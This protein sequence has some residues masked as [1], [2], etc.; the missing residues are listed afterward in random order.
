MTIREPRENKGCPASR[1]HVRSR[2]A[3]GGNTELAEENERSGGA[4][5]GGP[6]PVGFA[7]ALGAAAHDAAVAAQARLFL[8]EQTRL[9]HA[10]VTLVHLQS[11]DLR[12]EDSIRHWSLRVRHVSDV[13]KLGFELAVAFIVLALAIGVGAVIWQAVHA[14]G[15]VIRTFEVPQTF[16]AK[17][18]SGQVVA[19]KLLDRLTRM[20]GETDSSRAA[21]SFANDWTNDIK[22]EIPDTA[23]S[24]GEA[25]RFLDGWLGHEMHLSGELYE[26]PSGIALT[27][28]T[29]NE[30]G[31]TF[32][33]KPGELDS[34]I[35]RAAEAVFARAQ[36]YRYGVYLEGQGRIAESFSALR[37]LA[38]QGPKNETAWADVGL[39]LMAGFRGDD[40]AAWAFHAEGVRA[41]PDLPNLYDSLGPV[42][43]LEG[44]DQALLRDARRSLTLLKGGRARESD[45]SEIPSW[46]RS[47]ESLEASFLGDYR[48]ALADNVFSPGSG[49]AGFVLSSS[50]RYAA[51]LHDAALARDYLSQLGKMGKAGDRQSRNAEAQIATL[52]SLQAGDWRATIA[53]ADDAVSIAHH[54]EAETNGWINAEFQLRARVLPY[55]AYAHAMRG[56]FEAA[57]RIFQSLPLD[58]DICLRYRGKAAALRKNWT[59]AAHWFALVAARSPSIP[60]ADTDW[61]EMLLRKGDYDAAIANFTLANQKGPHFAD[62]LEMWGEALMQKSR[63]DLALAKFEEADTYAPNWG[64]LHLKWGEALLYAGHKDEAQRQ[65]ASA[66]ILDFS[67]ADET[68][69]A[70]WTVPHG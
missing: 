46:V 56:E 7:T 35:E 4:T 28:R 47:D 38:Q 54:T 36:P 15:L 62:P 60:S 70:R 52:I 65:F 61:G 55:L 59:G 58:C 64:R 20:Q 45:L 68:S 31:Q 30:P 49:G 48:T 10:Q 6:D 43:S 17:G 5:P 16:A 42:D 50:A 23:I 40:T 27:V 3:F 24:L 32:E 13:L 66:A 22:M 14:E 69:L 26:N 25:V 8:E 51:L 29:D 1:G 44:H 12:R 18:L 67:P 33:G 21:S 9:S 37:K 57:D 39:S 63:S 41:N 19:S 2:G 34:V 53:Q 11:D